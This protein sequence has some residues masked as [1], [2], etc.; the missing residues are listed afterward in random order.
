MSADITVF[1]QIDDNTRPGDPPFTNDPS[2][3]DLSGDC[4]LSAGKHYEFYAAISGVRNQSGVPPLFP[5]RGLPS[6]GLSD[7]REHI[8][9]DDP[10]VGWL[11]FAETLQA[12]QHMNIEVSSLKRPVQMLLRTMQAAEELYGQGRVRLV[13]EISD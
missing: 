3:W 2:T 10:N 7:L 5:C 8:E 13:F 12:L 6:T 1:L 4:G 11:T 9:T